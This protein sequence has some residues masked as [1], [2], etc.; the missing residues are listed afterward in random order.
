MKS[1]KTEDHHDDLEF[2]S[3]EG[4]SSIDQQTIEDITNN[5]IQDLGN[6]NIGTPLFKGVSTTA[7]STA[8]GVTGFLQMHRK[9][10]SM[11]TNADK[12]LRS[13]TP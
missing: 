7:S 1:M 4:T 13:E 9:S 10:I 12:N 3:D 11:F 5:N 6:N 8:T 2:S